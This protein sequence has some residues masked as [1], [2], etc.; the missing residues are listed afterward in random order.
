M[1]RLSWKL[2]GCLMVLLCWHSTSPGMQYGFQVGKSYHYEVKVNTTSELKAGDVRESM[3]SERIASVT[4]SV[5]AQAR[6][7]FV[8]DV[9]SGEQRWRRYVRTNGAVVLGSCEPG[10]EIPLFLGLPEGVPVVGAVSKSE[11]SVPLERGA[12]AARWELSCQN[13]DKAKNRA[14]FILQGVVDLPSDQ[15]I[16]RS[17]TVKGSLQWDF[18]QNCWESGEWT[19]VYG[20]GLA[21]K[22]FAVI[23]PMWSYQETRKVSFKSVS[24]AVEGQQ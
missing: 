14:G 19:L 23:R 1:C 7:V 18:Q 3:P 10:W 17:L 5:L 4:L 16:K 20:L 12:T 8:L 11:F 13:L 24:D 2:L 6:G 22:E 9:T 15:S 21:N